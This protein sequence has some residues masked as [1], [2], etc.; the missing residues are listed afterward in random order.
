MARGLYLLS[1]LTSH[2]VRLNVCR[3]LFCRFLA[4]LFSIGDKYVVSLAFVHGESYLAY[5]VVP[6]LFAVYGHG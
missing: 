5:R 6:L 1:S 4:Y 3:R 2:R